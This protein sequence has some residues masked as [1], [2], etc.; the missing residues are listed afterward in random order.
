MGN[1]LLGRTVAQSKGNSCLQELQQMALWIYLL[2][3]A[4]QELEQITGDPVS[5]KE[6]MSVGLLGRHV[7]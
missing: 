2:V 3:R 4:Q 6:L 1:N 5:K 7:T